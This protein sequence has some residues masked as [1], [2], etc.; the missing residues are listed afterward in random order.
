MKRALLLLASIVPI[1][2]DGDAPASG[3]DATLAD[4]PDAADVAADVTAPGIPWRLRA[5]GGGFDVELAGSPARL[6][7]RRAGATMIESPGTMPL[8]LIGTRDGGPSPTRFHDPRQPDPSGITWVAPTTVRAVDEAAGTVTLTHPATGDV[9]LRLVRT[10]ADVLSLVV[11]AQGPDVAMLRFDAPMDGSGYH[12]LGEQFAGFDARGRIVAMQL[13]V[14]GTDSGT[15]EAHVPVP[16]MVSPRGDGVFVETTEAGAFDVGAT[17]GARWSARF[18]GARAT[19]HLFAQ[20]TPRAVIAAYTR[21][22]G[23]PRLPPAWSFGHQQWRNAWDD[24]AQVL[25]DARRLRAEAIPTSTIWIDNPW[26]TSYSDHTIDR[27]RFRNPEAMMATLRQLGYRVIFWSVPFLDAVADGA[28]PQNA[29]ERLWMQARE[30]NLLVRTTSGRPY[31]TITRYG[32]PSGMPNA[33]GSPMDWTN[34][35]AT[36]FWVDQLRPIIEAGARGFKLDYGE[37]I[38]SDLAG[39]RPGFRFFNGDT[40][41]RGHWFYPQGYH[42]AYRAALDRWAGGD[43]FLIGR[44]S[45]WGGQRISD[46]IWPGDLDNDFSNHEGGRVGGLRAAIHGMVSLAESGFPSFASDTGGY[47]GGMPEREV[48]LRWAE[49]TAL[50]PF[51]QL[52]GAGTSHNP[53]AYDAE[54]TRIYRGLARLHDDLTPYFIEHAQ[55]AS[56][57]GVPPLVSAAVAFPDHPEAALDPETYLLGDDLFVAPVVTAGAT[58]RRVHVPPGSWVHWWTG[59]THPGPS[60]VT[61][62]AP[63]GQPVLLVREGAVIPMNPQEVESLAATEGDRVIDLGDRTTIRRMAAFPGPAATTRALP[64]GSSVRVAR[65]PAGWSLQWTP[66]APVT[67]LRSELFVG[68]QAAMATDVRAGGAALTRGA[69]ARDGTCTGC[70]DADGTRGVVWVVQGSAGEALIARGGS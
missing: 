13:H 56:R 4:A 28:T 1:A 22:T 44:A 38:V 26:Q 57:E 69:G 54:A 6:R 49:H 46:L 43:G 47:R 19:L 37:D 61:I 30:R 67:V 27:T 64:G 34:P 10:N 59:T 20:A 45:S 21:L 14:G 58:T 2:C 15:N 50:S 68:P 41:R 65:T 33:N 66:T 31:V 52:G 35:E 55:R 40:E 25:E 32:G 29:A 5:E 9:V 8:L 51:M 23:L 12:G 60:D 17:D 36:E 62:P 24:D 39:T 42:A 11:D 18:E 63:L 16:V 7:L 48:L 53:W 70:W 3:A